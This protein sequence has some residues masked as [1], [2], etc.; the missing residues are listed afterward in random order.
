MRVV[1]AAGC[2]GV[3]IT[4]LTHTAHIDNIFIQRVNL[5]VY[6]L[7]FYRVASMG[8]ENMGDVRV[9]H[10]AHGAIHQVKCLDRIRHINHVMEKFGFAEG[11]VNGGKIIILENQ[12]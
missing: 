7:G 5:D 4:R 1:D 9:P 8:T 6:P 12:E 10:K 11:P 2:L 3:P